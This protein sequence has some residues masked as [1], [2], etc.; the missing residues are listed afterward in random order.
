[1]NITRAFTL[2]EL[3]IAVSIVAVLSAIGLTV[4]NGVQARARD[5]RRIADINKIA[6]Y[7]EA[8]HQKTGR[9]PPSGARQAD[10]TRSGFSGVGCWG[11]WES[12]NT[13]NTGTQNG[14]FLTEL[15]SEGITEKLPLEQHPDSTRSSGCSYR[16][17]RTQCSTNYYAVVFAD[18][19]TD[20]GQSDERP[21]CITGWYEAD[22]AVPAQDKRDW[23]IFLEE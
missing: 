2:V 23:A 6:L 18:L 22:P 4:Y 7:L 20:S 16:Y 14:D 3:L 11:T 5:T 8:Y 9:Y 17:V 1:M 19:E 21:G 10:G 13:L 15:I 12:G